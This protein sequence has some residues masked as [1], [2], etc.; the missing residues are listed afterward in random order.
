MDEIRPVVAFIAEQ[1]KRDELMKRFHEACKASRGCWMPTRPM[2]SWRPAMRGSRN[3]RGDSRGSDPPLHE[4]AD[5]P[6]EGRRPAH[7]L[8][9]ATIAGVFVVILVILLAGGFLFS[10]RQ[11]GGPLG[12]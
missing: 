10:A 11:H 4:Q 9:L 12:P 8:R 6:A 5:G 1:T 3:S 2:R 7:K